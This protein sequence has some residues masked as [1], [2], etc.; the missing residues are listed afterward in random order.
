MPLTEPYSI[1]L[2]AMT[3]DPK[4]IRHVEIPNWSGYGVVFPKTA[5][6]T[7]RSEPGSDQAG[8]YILVGNAAEETIYIGEAD[9]VGERLKSHVANKER[10]V[11]GVYFFDR[12]HKMGKTEVQFL[13]TA[14]VTL[15]KTYRRAILL[16][17]TFPPSQ[18]WHRWPRP[19]LKG[20][21]PACC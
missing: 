8:V 21:L 11:W 19:P 13:E 3:G 12:N 4:G 9:P 2:F 17:K 1:T 6:N 10:W 5:V 16:N 14:L 18:R 20:I 15:A 7:L